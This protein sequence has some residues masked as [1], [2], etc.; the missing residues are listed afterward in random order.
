MH[1]TEIATII[2]PDLASGGE[3]VAEIRA[4]AG[5]LALCVSLAHGSDVEVVLG[6]E[7]CEKLL[8]ALQRA[9]LVV[10]GQAS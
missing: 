9:T 6:P 8:A 10:K 7:D 3:A 2:F 1:L 5:Q 4:A